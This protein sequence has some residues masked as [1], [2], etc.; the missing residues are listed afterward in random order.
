MTDL[1]AVY[2]LA[3]EYRYVATLLPLRGAGAYWLDGIMFGLTAGSKIRQVAI[4]VSA[5]FFPLTYI[6]YALYGSEH[7]MLVIWFGVYW[8]L[9]SRFVVAAIVL[10]R[11]QDVL[12]YNK[13]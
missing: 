6:V 13:N 2:D 12:I 8:L 4:I 11:N 1:P 7:A 5:I 9:A 3:I 10:W